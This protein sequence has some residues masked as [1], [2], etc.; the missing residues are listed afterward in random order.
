MP[1]LIVEFHNGDTTEFYSD[2]KGCY[3]FLKDLRDVK[4]FEIS[5]IP[6]PDDVKFM[7]RNNNGREGWISGRDVMTTL[8]KTT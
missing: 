8:R 3:D 2:S 7:G 5:A 1:R 6:I 4:S